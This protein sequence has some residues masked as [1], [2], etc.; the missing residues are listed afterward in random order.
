[1]NGSLF[2]ITRYM[3]RVCFKVSGGTSVPKLPP[4]YP[5]PRP[6]AAQLI[7]VFV[8]AY[9]DCWLVRRLMFSFIFQMGTLLSL[10]TFSIELNDGK[11]IDRMHI[12]LAGITYRPVSINP[13]LTNG[14][15]HRHHLGESTF[16]FRGIRSDF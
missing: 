15:S 1:M 2:S 3:H 12:E 9:A 8:F 5:P 7:C 11:V 16:M 10:P 6:R 13:Y 4:S 14:F